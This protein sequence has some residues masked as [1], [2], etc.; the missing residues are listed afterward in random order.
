MRQTTCESLTLKRFLNV[1]LLT[2]YYL[3]FYKSAVVL[4][5]KSKFS[6]KNVGFR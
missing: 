5:T 2:V 6:G 4:G 3:Y 1:S